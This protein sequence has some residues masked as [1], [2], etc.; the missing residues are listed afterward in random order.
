[1]ILISDHGFGPLFFHVNQQAGHYYG[2]PGVLIMAGPDVRS[3]VRIT[4]ASVHDI[5]PTILAL[6][7]LPIGEDMDG[8]IIV[9]ALTPEFLASY[10][11][12][13]VSSYEDGPVEREVLQARP[14]ENELP[15]EVK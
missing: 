4:D 9:E 5:T 10:P 1:M 2:P 12:Q 8:R 11:P 7:G 6:L 15:E 13:F 3:G 14:G